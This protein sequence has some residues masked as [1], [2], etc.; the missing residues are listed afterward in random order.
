MSSWK[1]EAPD[2]QAR[3]VA[4]SRRNSLPQY[5]RHVSPAVFSVKLQ[6]EPRLREQRE[7]A[8]G[9]HH[10]CILSEL[11]FEAAVGPETI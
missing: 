6:T 5:V 11:V 9:N 8:A 2:E 1:H 7:R 10:I 3:S 4:A